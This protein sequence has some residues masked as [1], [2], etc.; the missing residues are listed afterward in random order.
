M[1]A[2]LAIKAKMDYNSRLVKYHFEP[3]F[4]PLKKHCDNC[5]K[6]LSK[7]SFFTPYKKKIYRFNSAVLCRTCFDEISSRHQQLEEEEQQT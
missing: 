2:F 1:A 4:L 7:F 6:E 3:L 5:S